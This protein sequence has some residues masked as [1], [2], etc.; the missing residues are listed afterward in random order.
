VSLPDSLL[1]SFLFLLDFCSLPRSVRETS[2]VLDLAEAREAIFFSSTSPMAP[3][4]SARPQ[5]A[6]PKD[7]T[8]WASGREGNQKH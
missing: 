1:G 8:F 2:L 5:L 3:P 7:L 4:G 6:L